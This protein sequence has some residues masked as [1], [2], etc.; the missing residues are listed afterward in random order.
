MKVH[1][2]VGAEILTRV[3][4]PYPVV[5]VVR[6]H[7]ERGDGRGYPDGLKGEQIPITARILTVADWFDAVREDRQYRKAMSR[8]EA[9]RLLRDCS[10]TQFDP[11]VVEAFLANLPV[12]E[13]EIAAH[14]ASLKPLLS[15]TTQAGISESA[16]SATPAAGLA[17]VAS[18]PPDYLK[19]I[20]SAHA[21]VSALYE[22]A[23]T[24]SKSM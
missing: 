23:Q 17:Q 16:R 9:C 6:H 21:E 20:K 22:R 24:L 14:K 4:F 13:A 7:H 15:P 18:E 2:I 3:G 8:E 12:Y 5:P 19:Q 10:D 11:N 1:T